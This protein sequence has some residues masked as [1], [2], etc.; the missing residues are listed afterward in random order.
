MVAFWLLPQ[1]YFLLLTPAVLAASSQENLFEHLLKQLCLS[2][3]AGHEML[4][5]PRK[6]IDRYA[7][8]VCATIFVWQGD[9][10][11]VIVSFLL[12]E[13]ALILRPEGSKRLAVQYDR[14]VDTL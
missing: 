9:T 11:V 3:H 8:N 12:V 13:S 14:A 10:L 1:S 4:P 6:L 7:Y 5:V 2:C